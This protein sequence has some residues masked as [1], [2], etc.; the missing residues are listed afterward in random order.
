MFTRR[1]PDSQLLTDARRRIGRMTPEAAREY[2]ITVWAYGM[3]IAETPS[4][5]IE[6]D[7]GEWDMCLAVLQAV[8]ERLNPRT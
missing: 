2:S 6:D 3:R 7:L 5:H 1:S 8:H 4:P